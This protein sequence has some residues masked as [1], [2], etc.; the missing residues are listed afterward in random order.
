MI[1][2]ESPYLRDAPQ[3][4]RVVGRYDKDGDATRQALEAIRLELAE[5]SNKLDTL[6][7]AVS[8]PQGRRR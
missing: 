2:T 7:R 1:V 3:I 4:E 8:Q 6:V 5:Q